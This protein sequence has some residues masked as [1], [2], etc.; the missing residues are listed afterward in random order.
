MSEFAIFFKP[1]GSV[2]CSATRRFEKPDSFPH[3]VK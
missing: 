1:V 3:P 2:L